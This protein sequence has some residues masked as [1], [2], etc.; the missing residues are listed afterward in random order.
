MQGSSYAP[1]Q[2]LRSPWNRDV[3]TAIDNQIDGR[4]VLVLYLGA[5]STLPSELQKYN[6][7]C[8]LIHKD[9]KQIYLNT[10]ND[11][12]PTWQA[13]GPG[14]N[15]LPTPFL[16]GYVLTND[17]VDAFWS[18]VDLATMVTGLLDSDHIDLSDLANNSDFIDYLI[19]NSYFTS[20]LAGDTNFTTTLGNNNNFI[21]TLTSN[22]SFQNAVNTFVSGSGV[23][24]IDQTPDNGTFGLLAGDV[25]GVNDTYTVSLGAY[26]A[27]KLQVYLNGLIQLQGASDDY[28]ELVPGSGT[29]QFNTPP[30]TN[31]IITVVYS[32]SAGGGSGSGVSLEQTI[33][34]TA[35]GFVVGD[36]LRSAGTTGIYTKAQADTADNSAV[37]GLVT[38]VPNANTFELTKVGS[39]SITTGYPIGDALW[40]SPTTAGAMTN[41]E[42]TTIGQIRQPL[43]YVV[44]T[45]E[46]DIKIQ[47][48]DD[49]TAINGS[50]GN[51]LISSRTAFN[52]FQDFMG[53]VNSG[54]G[55][56]I[57]CGGL[58]PFSAPSGGFGV[59]NEP[60]HPGVL[61]I[62]LS[63][64]PGFAT[65]GFSLIGVDF[66]D[67][68]IE[69]MFRFNQPFSVLY[70]DFVLQF[71]NSINIQ[72]SL[73]S[74]V[75]T[76]NGVSTS[77][78][79]VPVGSWNVMNLIF[80]SAGTFIDVYINNSLI[81]SGVPTTTPSG[82]SGGITGSNV[83]FDYIKVNG[84]IT[85]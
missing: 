31:D 77:S 58:Y 5:A 17:G 22:I 82:S 18:L 53:D 25:D 70:L 33:T 36:W 8:I 51:G 65:T 44:G 64:G 47:R 1:L 4:T 41:V 50:I 76:V 79:T 68:K 3:Y 52:V 19:A 72:Y 11:T 81:V 10:G 34:Q 49:I 69:T 39:A 16:S 32:G 24:Q 67:L 7:G 60:N 57:S 2:F 46:I 6:V 13:F 38:A 56:S 54:I 20:S 75:L 55:G 66:N 45:N 9:E 14:T 30:A 62:P 83:D 21:N 15:S 43:G 23:L 61:S 28:V 80:N 71:P 74:G 37:I 12:T 63:P 35:H 59:V 85:R 73:T 27:G 26:A 29:F 48:G 84:T 40:L 78:V 42:P